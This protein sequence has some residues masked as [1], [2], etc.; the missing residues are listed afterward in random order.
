MS[1]CDKSLNPKGDY[2]ERYVLNCI[3]RGDT[4]YQVAV[5]SHSYDVNGFD[6]YKNTMDPAIAGADLRFW[7]NDSV[8]VFR[9]S[10]VTRLG[11]TRYDDSLKIYY[12]KNIHLTYNKPIEIEALLPN[13]RRLRSSGTTAKEII[14]DDENSTKVI[15]P[16]N[17]NLVDINWNGSENGYFLP[18]FIIT[19]YKKVNDQQEKHTV[20][21]PVKYVQKDGE[22]IPVYSRISN[23][24]GVSYN[25]DDIKR[26]LQLISDGD[27]DKSNYSVLI[28]NKVIVYGLDQNLVRYFSANSQDNSFTVRLDENDFSNIEG[29]FGVFGSYIA[30]SYTI[31]FTPE[32]LTDLG[33]TPIY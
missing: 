23:L 5:I 2:V 12:L 6:P 15:P 10:V 31:R 20:E 4:S 24:L 19:Y 13:G 17:T 3:L 26:A 11:N 1:S 18:R 32:F 7:Y 29:G 22:Y 27:P 8:F 14:F 28:S 16:V 33:Y 30:N 25:P 21:I 9:D